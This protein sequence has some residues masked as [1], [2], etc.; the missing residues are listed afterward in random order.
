MR[1]KKTILLVEDEPG[2]MWVN[3]SMFKELGYEV[4]SAESLAET[5]ARL[6]DSSPD[7]IVLDLML[8]DG[9]ALDFMPELRKKTTA[10]V[11]MLTALIKKDERLAGLRAG[12]DDYITK[13]YDNE[14]LCAR[15]AAFLRRDDM[16]NKKPPSDIFRHDS[17]TLNIVAK[18]AYM[19][20][21]SMELSGKEF[22]L[23]QIFVKNEDKTLTK[24]YLYEAVWE[25]KLCDDDRVIRSTI[26]RLRKKLEKANCRYDIVSTRGEGYIFIKG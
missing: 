14:E 12:G 20:G 25:Q 23:L 13:P 26:C 5:R 3:S 16:M 9:N 2:I 18:Q 22:S 4:I 21:K 19:G 15:V 11:L 6:A 10:P 17:I 1:D 7:V 24:E 8:P